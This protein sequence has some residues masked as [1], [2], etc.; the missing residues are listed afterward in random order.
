MRSHSWA[1]AYLVGVTPAARQVIMGGPAIN[2]R[3]G[4]DSRAGNRR[5]VAAIRR[6]VEDS[7]VR[8]EELDPRLDAEYVS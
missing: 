8:H 5:L 1:A 4:R 6:P 2:T 3:H 7:I